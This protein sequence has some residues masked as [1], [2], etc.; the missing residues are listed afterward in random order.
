MWWDRQRITALDMPIQ[1]GKKQDIGI[2]D[3]YQF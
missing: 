3:P 2:T 1:K